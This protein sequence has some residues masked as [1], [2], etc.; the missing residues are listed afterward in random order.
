MPPRTRRALVPRAH[1]TSIFWYWRAIS[2][3]I[4][5]RLLRAS[6]LSSRTSPPTLRRRDWRSFRR[7][8]RRFIVSLDDWSSSIGSSTPRLEIGF[9]NGGQA[10]LVH[11]TRGHRT[12]AISPRSPTG[13][14]ARRGTRRRTAGSWSGGSAGWRRLASS[15][16]PARA[17]ESAGTQR[18]RPTHG[19][20][21]NSVID[22]PPRPLGSQPGIRGVSPSERAGAF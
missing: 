5:A 2:L 8:L 10:N 14:A 16:S 15:R 20:P 12:R 3:L 19:N 7:F 22:D 17:S 21:F 1:D 4:S 18:D 9:V 13:A 6:L 11:V